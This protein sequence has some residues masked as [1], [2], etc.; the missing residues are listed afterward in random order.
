[1]LARVSQR[2]SVSWAFP[3]G[4]KHTARSE[5][6]HGMDIA[7]QFAASYGLWIV[8]A[9][10]FLA[11]HWF[12]LRHCGAGHEHGTPNAHPRPSEDERDRRALAKK[13]TE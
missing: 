6:G 1:M 10:V 8:L 5:I 2:S 7:R 4:H 11:M 9:I 3:R 12:G 13:T